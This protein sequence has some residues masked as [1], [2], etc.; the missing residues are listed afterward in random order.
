MRTNSCAVLAASAASQ[1]QGK[2]ALKILM[3]E[4]SIHVD[5]D[6]DVFVD[7]FVHVHVEPVG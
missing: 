4:I 6:V 2:A 1:L 7:V 5:V 3:C